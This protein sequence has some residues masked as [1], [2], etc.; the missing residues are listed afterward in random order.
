[1]LHTPNDIQ[2][3]IDHGITLLREEK[4]DEAEA[5]FLKAQLKW[6]DNPLPFIGSARAAQFNNKLRLSL[7]RW[8]TA[9]DKFSSNLQILKGL[10]NI[11]LELKKFRKARRCFTETNE[12]E[13][14][15]FKKLK[16]FMRNVNVLI[17]AEEYTKAEALLIEAQTRWP[18]KI[19]PFHA[20]HRLLEIKRRN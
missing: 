10:G 20:H 6:P 7:K 4:Y 15:S 2:A 8:K 19:N 1:M 13:S 14:S 9:R 18:E 5:V 11:Y 12:L 17:S 3:F 16:E